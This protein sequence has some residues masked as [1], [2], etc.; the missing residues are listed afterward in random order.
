VTT[1]KSRFTTVPHISVLFHDSSTPDGENQTAIRPAP[2]SPAGG[3]LDFLD[4]D[5]NGDGLRV[6][7]DVGGLLDNATYLATTLSSLNDGAGVAT[8]DGNDLK[9]TLCDG[10]IFEVD[11]DA[12]NPQTIEGLLTEI[13]EAAEAATGK[14]EAMTYEL[15]H[16]DEWEVIGV[17]LHDNST[18]NCTT[19]FAIR[20]ASASPAGQQLNVLGTDT[21][22]DG[23]ISGGPQVGSLTVRFFIKEGSAVDLSATIRAEDFE[24]AVALGG[25]GLAIENGN[26]EITLGTTFTFTD[27]GVGDAADGKVYLDEIFSSPVGDVIDLTTPTLLGSGILPL[28]ASPDSLNELLG[29]DPNHP[30]N[31]S[32]E[33]PALLIS[34]SGFPLDLNIST[35]DAFDDLL[36]GFLNFSIGSVCEGILLVLEFLGNSELGIFNEPIPLV[37][38][39]INE[40]LAIGDVLIELIEDM[41]KDPEQLKAD[42]EALLPDL[43][44]S[45]SPVGAIPDMYFDLSVDQ[46]DKLTELRD[47]LSF[48]LGQEDLS[49]LATNMASIVDAFYDF[50]DEIQ[51]YVDVTQLISVIDAIDEMLPSL[52]ALEKLVE[53]ALDLKDEEFE[54]E[55]KDLNPDVNVYDRGVIAMLNLSVEYSE[56]LPLDFEIGTGISAIPIQLET[57][58]E[59]ALSITGTLQLDFGM[60]ISNPDSV[61]FFLADTSYAS[62]EADIEGNNLGATLTIGGIGAASIVDA[63]IRLKN[64][65]TD[66]FT[67]PGDDYPYELSLEIQDT[68]HPLAFVYLDGAFQIQDNYTL[69]N[70]GG[71]TE[72]TFD[73][74][75]PGSGTIRVLYPSSSGATIE[76]D[77][78]DTDSDGIINLADF[79]FTDNIDFSINGIISGIMPV[80]NIPLVDDFD[81][82]AYFNVSDF[83][84]MELE[85]PDGLNVSLGSS[86][87]C[88]LGLIVDG[89]RL[90]LDALEVGL[91]DG[92]ANLPLIGDNIDLSGAGSFIA[93]LRDALNPLMDAL[94]DTEGLR[95]FLFENL[96]PG[97]DPDVGLEL[98]ILRQGESQIGSLSDIGEES[99]EGKD[100]W[101]KIFE[102]DPKCLELMLHLGGQF[103]IGT[104]FDLGLD[105]I[106]F[107]VSTSGGIELTFDYDIYI[108]LGVSKAEG[109]YFIFNEDESE[110]NLTLSVGLAEGTMLEIK[111]FFLK[112]TAEEN[113]NPQP[114]SDHDSDLISTGFAGTFA[115]NMEGDENNHL[116]LSDLG[117]LSFDEPDLTFDVYV[118]LTLQAMIGDDPS[119]PSITADLWVK[120]T[121]APGG[122]NPF[123]GDSLEVEINNLALD[124]GDMITK[125][126]GPF[127]QS[128]YDYIEPIQPILANS[129]G[130]T[131]SRS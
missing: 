24:L 90:F 30:W 40:L 20:A 58:G 50:I 82:R 23:N 4:T 124:L 93:D 94:E 120:W 7:P 10:T 70:I 91:T 81:F 126:L 97:S 78:V 57:G 17:I 109:V 37:G 52:D 67:A 96:G 98:N 87:N 1:W 13:V 71:I 5:S 83:S 32:S 49:N 28:V 76:F 16:N 122:D 25:I 38:K 27:P 44:N 119:L 8:I 101:A 118:D 100:N 12:A 110:I 103:T 43:D 3:D 48:A 86:D 123:N 66:E 2:T 42:I 104:D 125:I 6:T 55:F 80:E 64:M 60:N 72:L 51:Y 47:A 106:I 9:V 77:V 102:N 89:F 39:S 45:E 129:W 99:G 41:C 65:V 74:G 117:T 33:G 85:F 21:N 62:L 75:E 84:D 69:Q 108:G 68:L 92:L 46:Q 107:E 31:D 116:P 88:N 53:D 131:L 63:F 121:F 114:A 59:I 11:V 29:I 26:M 36:N 73:G 18:D 95:T 54:L 35:N 79:D 111:L 128:V 115:L 22:G 127:I 14:A 130:G 113:T 34:V 15:D 105:G 56:S 112:L 19:T 61:S